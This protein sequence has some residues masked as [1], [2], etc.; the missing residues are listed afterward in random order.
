MSLLFSFDVSIVYYSI[1]IT[2]RKS[3]CVM[4]CVQ[5]KYQYFCTL[6]QGMKKMFNIDENNENSNLIHK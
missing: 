2:W 4:K 5:V 6:I 1:P 3:N